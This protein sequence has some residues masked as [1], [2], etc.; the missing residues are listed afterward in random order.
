VLY[1]AIFSPDG[2]MLGSQSLKVDQAFDAA[3]YQQIVSKGMLLHLD[4]NQPTGNNQ[5]RMVVRDNRTGHT[6]SL[7]AP[8]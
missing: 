6:G 8:L 7:S 5:L 2:K 1:T 4:L 3:T